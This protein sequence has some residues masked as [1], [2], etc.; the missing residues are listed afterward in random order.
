MS[1]TG[2]VAIRVVSHLLLLALWVDVCAFKQPETLLGFIF[3][4]TG[5]GVL[6]A[7]ERPSQLRLSLAPGARTALFVLMTI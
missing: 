2:C 6:T 4:A 5:R 1:C 3:T 7:L